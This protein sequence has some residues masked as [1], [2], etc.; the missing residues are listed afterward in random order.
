MDQI[1]EQETFIIADNCATEIKISFI[2][3]IIGCPSYKNNTGRITV[4]SQYSS[5]GASLDLIAD[6]SGPY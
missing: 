4:Y 1:L 5:D 6:L 3:I 2:A